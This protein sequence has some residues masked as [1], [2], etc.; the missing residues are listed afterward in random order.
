MSENSAA[1]SH[2][3]AG[4]AG[5]GRASPAPSDLASLEQ[6]IRDLARPRPIYTPQSVTP[7]YSLRYDWAGWLSDGG[8]FPEGTADAI[9]GTATF[10]QADGLELGEFRVEGGRV[11]VIFGAIPQISPETFVAR[12]KGRLQHALRQAGDPVKFSRKVSFRS[13]GENV[14]SAVEG[15]FGK[16]VR[17]EGFVDPRYEK[18]LR[19]F[20]V[21][22]DE[23][24]LALLVP[25]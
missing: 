13:L 7:V 3:P 12:V 5:R 9:R 2:G 19:A 11:Q 23:V 6:K 10:W 16:Q 1:E 25:A 14:R 24:D 18:R 20:T 17:K 4:Q 22:R 8:T 15:Y 21:E